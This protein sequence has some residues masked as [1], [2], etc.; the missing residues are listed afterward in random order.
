MPENLQNWMDWVTGITGA[1]A[2]DPILTQPEIEAIVDG[3]VATFGNFHTDPSELPASATSRPRGI[4]SDPNDLL[5]Y[6]ADGG[7][8]GFDE[9][10]QPLPLPIVHILKTIADDS[11][12]IEY[13]VWIDEES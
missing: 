10:D 3:V 7:L 4:F 9:F 11:T 2:P 13:E 12:N 6:L 5:N 8:V 1:D